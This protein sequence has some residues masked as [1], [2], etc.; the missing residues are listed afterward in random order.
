MKIWRLRPMPLPPAAMFFN[1]FSSYT[2][3]DCSEEETDDED[4]DVPQHHAD[5]APSLSQRA[6]PHL[7]SSSGEDE[8]SVEGVR[9]N[10]AKLVSRD[11]SSDVVRLHP[12]TIP[13]TGTGKRPELL[14]EGSSVATAGG[15]ESGYGGSTEDDAQ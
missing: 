4:D 12:P 10:V 6:N 8:G 2:D 5:S 7:S 3:S 14:H 1:P 15:A 11:D 13:S 9:K